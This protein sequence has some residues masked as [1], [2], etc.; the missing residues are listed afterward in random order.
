MDR[1]TSRLV[2][3]VA[4]VGILIVIAVVFAIGG[5]PR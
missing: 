4:L 1:R 5:Y 3:G 2:T